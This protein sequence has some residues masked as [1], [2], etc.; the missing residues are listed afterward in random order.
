MVL[1][2]SA[3]YCAPCKMFKP[4]LQ[5]VASEL[6]IGIQ[7]IDAD[8]QKD[9]VSRYSVTSVPT[10]IV[11]NGGSVLFRNTGVMDKSR[12]RQVLSQFR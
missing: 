1:Y 2:F 11:E 6:G 10:L 5:E 9:L 3:P 8:Q 12:L 4:V 7:Y